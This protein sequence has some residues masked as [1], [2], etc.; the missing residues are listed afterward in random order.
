MNDCHDAVHRPDKPYPAFSKLKQAHPE[1]LLG[2]YKNRPKHGNWSAYDFAVPE[3]RDLALACVDEVCRMYDVDGIHLDFFRHLNYFR[4]VAAGEKATPEHLAM[5]TDLI[6]R[7]RRRTEELGLARKRPFLLAVRVPDSVEY[8][9]AL[10]LDVEQWLR[11]G[12]VDLLVVGEFQLRPWAESVALGHRYGV[13]VVAGLSETRERAERE[14]FRRQK[15]ESYRG[16]AA[17]AW[18]AGCDGLYIF[19]FYDAERPVLSEM[20]DAAKLAKLEQWVFATVRSPGEAQRWVA[21]G[22]S[23]ASKPWLLPS[24]PW[25]LKTGI[26]RTVELEA[27]DPAGRAAKLYALLTAPQAKVGASLGGQ[28]LRRLPDEHGWACYDVPGSCLQSGRNVASLTLREDVTTERV[29][30]ARD[31]ARLWG[32]RGQRKS[33]AVFG[34]LTPAGLRTVDRGTNSGDYHYRSFG[35]AVEPGGKAAITVRAKHVVGWSSFA[36]ANGRNEERLMLLPDRI[37]CRNSGLEYTM[38]TTSAFH[39]YRV[40][41]AGED[42]R[43]FVDGALRIDG[44]GKYTAPAAGGRTMVL[45]GAA[46]STDTGEAIWE[47]AKL[48]TTD[49]ALQDLVLALPD[50]AATSSG[51]RPR[52]R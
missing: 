52:E 13:Q 32:V 37:R 21:D 8:C 47:C 34:E 19:N 12:L 38:D 23:Y 20:Q 1:W 41:I 31:I 14:P 36:F 22:A 5:M 48:E 3:V 18:A 10:G 2:T 50:G 6:R 15:R 46:T 45:L 17:A 40:E 27:G 4:E 9:R 39:D 51:T 49:V 33:D 28:E 24:H 35:W 16:R 7:M 25:V 29:F 44:R 42:F 11:E 26:P 30:P 43:V